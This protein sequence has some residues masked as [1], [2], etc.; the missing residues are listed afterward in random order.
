MAG[1]SNEGVLTLKRVLNVGGGAGRQLPEEYAGWKQDL[2]DIDPAVRPDICCDALKL[3]ERSTAKGKYDAVYCSHT[4]EHFYEH[5]VPRLFAGFKHVLR[6]GG[7]VD[8]A[9][10]DVLALM[11]H[12]LLSGKDIQDEWYM[13]SGGPI[14]YHDV[15]YGWSLAM[16]SGNL[17]YAH[18]CGFTGKS[19]GEKLAA[20][21][22]KN[23]KVGSDGFNLIA[24]AEV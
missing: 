17:Y 8:I 5:D 18:K 4:V 1:W 6:R 23:I 7:A 19:L 3:T 21:G 14:K 15:L 2:L 13:S 9:V 16:R 20:A 10:P 22:F 11:R 12:M 24:K